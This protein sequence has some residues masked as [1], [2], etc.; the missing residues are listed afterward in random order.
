MLKSALL[1]GAGIVIGAGA[2]SA[3]NAATGTPVYNVYEAAVTDEAA[4][5]KDLAEIEPVIKANGGVRVA[6]G[7]NKA[8][9]VRG[10]APANRFVIIQWPNEAAFDKGEKDGISAWIEKHAPQAREVLVE[11]VEAK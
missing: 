4:Y 8:K 3:L 2:I 5:T 6:G 7:F 9:A 10:T 11:G 1:V